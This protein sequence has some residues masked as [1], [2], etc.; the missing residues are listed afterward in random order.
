ML[1]TWIADPATYGLTNVTTPACDVDKISTLTGGQVD[2][3][4]SLF[5]NGTTGAPFNT[6]VTGAD[7]TSWLFADTVHPST[8][9]HQLF[10]DALVEQLRAAHWIN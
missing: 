7:V 1:R 2:D 8:K 10:S 5:C 4:T 9:G 6:L 3:G